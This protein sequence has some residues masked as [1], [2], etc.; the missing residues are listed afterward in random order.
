MI[1]PM[2]FLN[3]SNRPAGFCMACSSLPCKK[4]VDNWSRGNNGKSSFA[5]LFKTITCR[6]WSS[7]LESLAVDAVAF[8]GKELPLVSNSGNT[9]GPPS[10][11][12]PLCTNSSSLSLLLLLLLLLLPL[13]TASCCSSVIFLLFASGPASAPLALVPAGVALFAADPTLVGG[14]LPRAPDEAPAGV[15]IALATPDPA[16][17]E[18]LNVEPADS[19]RSTTQPSQALLRTW[20]FLMPRPKDDVSFMVASLQSRT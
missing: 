8:G 2:S 13:A 10:G 15:A 19:K 6:A 17:A 7:S 3:L 18:L 4:C 1:F 11:P 9:G 16:G 5:F 14:V 12:A 20:P